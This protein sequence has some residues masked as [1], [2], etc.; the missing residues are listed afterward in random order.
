M[1]SAAH[2]VDIPAAVANSKDG[3]DDG[4]DTR[5]DAPL[6]SKDGF[7]GDE[8]TRDGIPTTRF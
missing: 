8:A 5:D 6:A 4:E 3:F 7:G 2:Q 1:S